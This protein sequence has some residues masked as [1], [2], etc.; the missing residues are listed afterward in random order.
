MHDINGY[1]V[2]NRDLEFVHLDRPS[3]DRLEGRNAPLGMSPRQFDEFKRSLAYTLQLEEIDTYDVRLQGSSA[4]FFSSAAKRL[5]TTK[6]TLLQARREAGHRGVPPI[7]ELEIAERKV[8]LQWPDADQRPVRRPFDVL[9]VLRLDNQSDYDV[10]LSSDQAVERVTAVMLKELESLEGLTVRNKDYDFIAD[11]IWI[12]VLT[13]LRA[14]QEDRS[15]ILGRNVAVKIF[16][17]EGPKK[18]DKPYSSHRSDSDWVLLNTEDP[19]G[20]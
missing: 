14:W 20:E 15:K 6:A 7:R 2:T 16:G 5:P 11:D 4:N 13:E 18:I 3:L 8:L 9:H 12:H 19:G 10:Q 1:A 17:T